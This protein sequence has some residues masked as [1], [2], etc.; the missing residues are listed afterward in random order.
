MGC[1]AGVIWFA[2][3]VLAITGIVKFLFPKIELADMD[4]T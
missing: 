1:G 3:L 2:G 4:S